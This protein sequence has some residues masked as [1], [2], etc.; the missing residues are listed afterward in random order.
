VTSNRSRELRRRKSRIAYRLR[1]REW[2]AQ[3][4]PMFTRTRL[5]FDV[6]QRDCAVS[7]GGL[8]VMHE[9][10][11]RV[12]LFESI[13]RRVH[14]LKVH[15]PYHESD[16]VLNFAYNA[17][18]G[19]QTIEDL[20]LLR[21]NEAY[22]DML[23]APRIPDPTTAGDFCRRF[24]EETVGE[25]QFAIHEAR[26]RV[27]AQQPAS[28]FEQAII[29]FDGTYVATE[30]GCKAGVDI[31]Y[32][33]EWGYHVLVASLAS[34]REPLE[35]ENRRG[36][37]PSHEG[38][39][40]MADRTIARVREAGFRSVLLRGDT[41]FSQTQHLDR[42]NDE[43]V[44]FVFGY[45]QYENLVMQAVVLPDAAW[46]VLERK[47]GGDDAAKR[48]KPRE[49]HREAIVV[50]REYKNL[51]LELEEVAEMRYRPT[52]CAREYRMVVVKKT[53]DVRRGQLQLEPDTEFFFYITNL[54]TQSPNDIVLLANQ[55]CNQENLL[56]QMKGDVHALRAPVDTLVANWAYMVM[57]AIAWSLKAWLALVLP[58]NGRWGQHREEERN[59]LLR[60]EFRTFLNWM[61]RIPAQV[62]RTGRRTIVRYLAWTPLLAALLRGSDIVRAMRC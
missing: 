21:N 32:K 30:G 50:E 31:N 48:R 51:R 8:G 10:A 25:L 27:W 41:A 52:E 5:N 13:D 20:E 15:K 6:A 18:S 29:D 47:G 4:R 16:H 37:R 12:G 60:M 40:A 57:T 42:W 49:K 62:L 14:L 28:F 59:R 1:D 9:L 34:T 26:L 35:I 39:A 33:R 45:A 23:G 2:E 55:R 54:E 58:T 24:T 36:N 46:R 3:A 19:G 44:H 43:D 22:L 11:K 17:L 38:A 61:I 56:E 7:M 53:I